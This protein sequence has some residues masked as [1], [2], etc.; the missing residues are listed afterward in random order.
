MRPKHW[1]Y[2]IPLRL[3]SLF[4]WAQADQELDDELR[5]H[6]E[7]K[8]DEFVAKGMTPEKARR[9]ARLDLGGVE[10]VKEE[11]RDARRVNLIQDFV[12][13]LHFGLRIL[14]KSPGFTVVAILTLA[15]GIGANTAIFSMM[16]A[17]LLRLLPV[18]NPQE[19]VL[20][21]R[22]EPDDRARDGFTNALWE[23]VRDQED[24]FA[25]VFAWS[26]SKPFAMEWSGSVREVQ[27]LFVSGNYFTTLGVNA[28]AGRMIAAADDR[29]GCAPVAVLSYG[30]WE[31]YF[32]RERDVLGRTLSLY[33]QPF[34]VI[35]VSAPRFYGVEVGKEFDVAVPIC[36][37]ALFDKRNTESRSR[38]WLSIMARVKPGITPAQLSARL[39]TLSPGVMN[40]ALP[41]WDAEGQRR[42][43]RAKLVGVPADVG[44]SELRGEFGQALRVLMV[45]VA[46]V[47][48][49]ACANIASLMLARGTARGKE[50]AVRKALGAARGRLIRQ[51]LTESVLI[52][53]AGAGLGVLFAKW[54]GALLVRQLATAQD[55]VF[56][57][58]SI[59]ARVLAFTA[60]SAVLTA[61]MVGLLPA[62]R[63]TR[64]ALIEAMKA[65][66][67]AGGAQGLGAGR[68]IVIGQV[69]LTL[70]LLIGG[71]LLLRSFVR[72]VTLDLGF[73]RSN[74]LVVSATPPWFAV[75]TAKAGPEKRTVIYEEIERRLRALPG[76]LS[77]ARA[78]TTPI[79]DDNWL[80]IIHTDARNAPTGDE[81]SI[82]LNF[83]S[84]GYFAILRSPLLQ[85][86]DFDGHD[87]KNSAHVAIVNETAVRKFFPSGSVLGHFRWGDE[88]EQVEIVGVVKDSKYERVREV[89]PPTVFF[90][91]AQIPSRASAEEFVLRTSVAPGML[92]EPVRRAAAEV[93]KDIPLKF[94]TLAG[95]VDDDLV[96][97]RLLAA[98]SG[99]FGMLGLLLAMIGL[100]GAVS[101][102]VT[103]RQTEFGVRMALGAQRG[104]ILRLVL[105]E[106]LLI[107]VVGVPIGVGVALGSVRMLQS[108]LFGIAAQDTYTMAA[109]VGV[110]SVVALVAGYLPARRAMRVD[111]MVALRYE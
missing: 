37:S 86:R 42:F 82:Y 81:A 49:I 16:D 13:D 23:G 87:L 96:Q 51:L 77:T 17:V 12:Q 15:L 47:M 31:T 105:G 102:L 85:G 101:Y 24:V 109:A 2:T 91:A 44:T 55:D 108:L 95:Q 25:G 45:I 69:A 110:Q 80:Q 7:R 75:D 40:A 14:R 10:K 8:T 63:S 79:G 62:F 94:R 90:P 9:Q 46:L 32:G 20:L 36:A 50:I 103:Q 1:L 92:I 64:I 78:F 5:D 106:V 61:I 104:S 60:L 93:S 38:W 66:T 11:C 88:P 54:S 70:V 107:L 59:N 41:D 21:L 74:V 43:L 71:G 26:R 48:L 27:G 33:G 97:E 58:L 18:R 56:L 72:L 6:L 19:L 111:P 98:V 39:D 52:S 4:R 29:P 76:V 34:E 67:G 89:V 100:F 57:D 83:V 84:P 68:W 22:Q 53:F 73:D 30:F 28:A 65:R 3:R 99:F 35:G